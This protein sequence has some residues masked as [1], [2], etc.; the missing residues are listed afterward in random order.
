MY[1]EREREICRN[2][3]EPRRR[4]LK[5]SILTL[6]IMEVQVY[7]YTYMCIHIYRCV[8][9]HREREREIGICMVKPRRRSLKVSVFEVLYLHPVPRV[10]KRVYVYIY[11]YMYIYVCIC[12]YIWVVYTCVCVCMYRERERERF[13]YT[14]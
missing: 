9:V 12:I 8:Y 2:M 6:F 1:V 4:S 14:G 13:V 3:V 7:M 5:F 11:S 10:N